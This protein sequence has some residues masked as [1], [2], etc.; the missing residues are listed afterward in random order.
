MARITLI[1]PQTASLEVQ[2][3]YEH[4]LRGRPVNIHKAMANVPQ[5]LTPFIAM[6][7]AVG[8]MWPPRMYELI[9]LRVSML[10]RCEY[11]TQHHRASATR[12]G[13]T[14]QDLEALTDPQASSLSDAEKAVLAYVEKLTLAPWKIGDEDVARLKDFNDAQVVDLHLLVALANFTNRIT[15]PLALEVEPVVK[16][17]IAEEKQK[18]F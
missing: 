11:C 3:I 13:V 5:S 10:N 15:G 17:A 4:R 2:N 7:A 12:A 14:S 6:Y 8:R 9:Y 16:A 18:Q 1:E